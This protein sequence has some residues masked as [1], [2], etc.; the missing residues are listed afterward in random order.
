MKYKIFLILVFSLLLRITYLANYDLMPDERIVLSN[1]HG[2]NQVDF[3]NIEEGIIDINLNDKT[4]SEV[5]YGN[6]IDEGGN[7]LAHAISVYAWSGIFGNST[8]ALRLMGVLI[9]VVSFFAF[10]NLI[11]NHFSKEILILSLFLFSIHPMIVY[12]NREI[13]TYSLA[14]LMAILLINYFLNYLKKADYKSVIT[15]FVLV[16]ITGFTHFLMFQ[17]FIVMAITAL[18]Y[19]RSK[20]YLLTLFTMASLFLLIFTI[21]YLDKGF[22]AF[23]GIGLRNQGAQHNALLLSSNQTSIKTILQGIIDLVINL[24]GNFYKLTGYRNRIIIVL[25]IPFIVLIIF[26]I[27]KIKKNIKPLIK[28]KWFLIIFLTLSPFI[29]AIIL[30]IKSGHIT[31]FFPKYMSWSIPF[32]IIFLATSYYKFI[33]KNKFLKINFI[34]LCSIM[35]SSNYFNIY[36]IH[37]K[38]NDIYRKKNTLILSQ[39]KNS[40]ENIKEITFP[41]D[42]LII[43][44]NLQINFTKNTIQK[45][46]NNNNQHITVT[47]KNE[48][49]KIF[50]FE[51]RHDEKNEVIENKLKSIFF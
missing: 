9:F 23:E 2:F 5:Y 12:H 21:W 48:V 46:K 8:L 10:K 42:K 39:I 38:N 40:K 32:F 35:L 19:R 24:S 41:Y 16:V 20:L 44:L 33:F 28:P 25:S 43:P 14:I 15:L 18:I 34:A 50:K 45:Y 1:A 31:S 49:K 4:I 37:Y 27:G 6:I 17:F 7:G 51:Y 11:I 30:A 13:R 47:Y 26:L 36:D 29:L 22:L 3:Q